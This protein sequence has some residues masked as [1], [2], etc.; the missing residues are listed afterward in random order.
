MEKG[1]GIMDDGGEGKREKG[2]SRR[3]KMDA[4][5]YG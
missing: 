4:G 3:R 5:M 1:K 2:P